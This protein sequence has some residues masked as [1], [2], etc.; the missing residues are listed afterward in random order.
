VRIRRVLKWVGRRGIELFVLEHRVV[1]CYFSRCEE[2]VASKTGILLT[3]VFQ[4]SDL[5]KDIS[6]P[7]APFTSSAGLKFVLPQAQSKRNKKKSK[8]VCTAF[9]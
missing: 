6:G 9:H 2:T 1:F 3:R 5:K 4:S 8:P 7:L